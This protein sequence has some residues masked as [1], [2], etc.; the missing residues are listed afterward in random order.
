MTTTTKNLVNVSFC[1]I[2]KLF[3]IYRNEEQIHAQLEQPTETDLVEAL[4]SDDW[5]HVFEKMRDGYRVR[6]SMRIY[7]DMLGCVPPIR[8]KNGSFYVGEAYAGRFH[9]FFEREKDGKC[10]GQLK[11]L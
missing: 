11:Q 7:F 1:N 8:Y 2:D 6:V 5:K 4:Q 3:Y 10:Y 9:H